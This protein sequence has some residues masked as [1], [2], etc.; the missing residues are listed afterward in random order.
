[1]LQ[2]FVK[3][4]AWWLLGTGVLVAIAGILIANQM[5]IVRDAKYR[6]EAYTESFAPEVYQL[7]REFLRCLHSVELLVNNPSDAAVDKIALA[8]DLLQSRLDIV[9]N[10]LASETVRKTQEYVAMRPLLGNAIA[11][12]EATLQRKAAAAEDWQPLQLEMQALR[13]AVNMLTMNA[14]LMVS[15]QQEEA[16]NIQLRSGQTMLTLLVGLLCMLLVAAASIAT[17][18]RRG[19]QEQERLEF[20]NAQARAANEKAD[21]ANAGKT[22][23]LANM[24][25]ELRTPLNGMLGMLS[26]LEATPVNDQQQDYIKTANHSAKHL[27]SL[28]ND[29]L[30]ASA[31]EAGRMTLKPE[32]LHLP[33]L[34]DDVYALMRP[35][36]IEKGLGLSVT[37]DPALPSW[38]MVDGTRFKQ[39]L[40]NLV[41]NALKFSERGTVSL[42]VNVVAGHSLKPGEMAQLRVR[43]LDEGTGMSAEVLARLFQRFEQGNASSAMRMG[44]SGLGLEISR[45]LARRMGGDI[46]A[47]SVE[48]EG[49]V[50]TATMRLAVADAPAA[51]AAELVIVRREPGS[52]G[53]NLLVAEDNAINRKYMEVLLTNMGHQVRFAEHG[54]IAVREVQKELPDLVLMDLH[55]PE[56]DGLQAT[57]AIRK[58]PAPFRDVTIIALTADVFEESKERVQASG[59]DEFLTKPVNVLSLEAL[60]VRRFG[61][62]GASLLKPPPAAPKAMPTEGP[63]SAPVSAPVTPPAVPAAAAPAAPDPQATASSDATGAAPP[64]TPPVEPPTRPRKRFRAGDVAEHLNMVMVGELCVGITVQGY[65]S[66][67][68]G[69]MEGD[70]ASYND[71]LK[72]LEAGNTAALLELGHSLKGVTASLGLA[73]LSRLALTIEKQGHAF[74]P[75]DC[76]QHAERLRES[77]A[78]TYAICARMGLITNT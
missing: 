2:S 45:N 14:S 51:P 20:L 26:L 49:S 77:W 25:H 68:S 3:K 46:Q 29:I 69:A 55:M 75:E 50:F 11:R 56:V 5:D 57:E 38:V 6:K 30:D 63:V 17:R 31:M 4:R 60:L 62:R 78:T 22:R 74:S 71:L 23:F 27:L 10:S 39:I 48:G 67:L 53:L 73:A 70:A 16:L 9:D 37:Q 41:S 52:P 59:M 19:E 72:A 44:G 61:G 7:E 28:L 13:P 24:S 35:M 76:K 47:T 34:I 58:L 43:V 1:M 36:A 15:M 40:L 12:A 18:Q 21:A 64:G 33:S 66:L 65:Q 42:A 54:G 32:S 8:L